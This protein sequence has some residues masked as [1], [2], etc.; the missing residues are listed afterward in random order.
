MDEDDRINIATAMWMATHG[1]VPPMTE[2]QESR[3]QSV[4][5]VLEGMG[6]KI[7]ADPVIPKDSL[8]FVQDGEVV[9]SITGIGGDAE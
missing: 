4:L 9:G 6:F 8:Y 3:A 5:D 7:V 2:M 1:G